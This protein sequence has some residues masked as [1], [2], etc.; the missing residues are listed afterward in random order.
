MQ[1]YRSSMVTDA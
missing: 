1:E